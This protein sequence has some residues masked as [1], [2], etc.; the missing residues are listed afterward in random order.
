MVCRFVNPFFSLHS[1]LSSI[2]L[3]FLHLPLSFS[4]ISLSP[5]F[6][7]LS[8]S[9]IVYPSF[10]SFISHHIFSISP[11]S[12]I[13]FSFLLLSHLL[14]FCRPSLPIF[15]LPL[16][17]LASFSIDVPAHPFSLSFIPSI[18]PPS[19]LTLL[20][21]LLLLFLPPTF[22]PPSLYLILPLSLLLPF[23][24]YSLYLILPLSLF[25]P[26]ILYSLSLLLSLH[27]CSSSPGVTRN[28]K[29][30]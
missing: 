7:P 12:L 17:L 13:R 28:G 29:A 4:P 5:P 30:E 21:S 23:I 8:L 3:V 27:R 24:S 26:F 18:S 25:P 1:F 9:P 2:F 20:L 14:L 22:S 10:Y 16:F 19:Y 11:I 15:L 6:S